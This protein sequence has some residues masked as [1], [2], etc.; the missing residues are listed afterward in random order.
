MQAVCFFAVCFFASGMAP[1]H[2]GFFCHGAG[3]SSK[4]YVM[5]G[6]FDGGGLRK[7]KPFVFLQCVFLQAVWH[8]C[9]AVFFVMVSWVR[10]VGG[11]SRCCIMF[12]TDSKHTQL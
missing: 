1:L 2:G 9:M 10:A 4:K 6:V 7:C 8:P 3:G 12:L 11:R 5:T